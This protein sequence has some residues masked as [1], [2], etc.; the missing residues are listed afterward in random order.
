MTDQVG[1][2][3]IGAGVVGLAIGRALALAGHAPL[4]LEGEADLGSWTSSRNSE[5]IHA[6]I[7]YPQGS[8]KARLCVEGK[9]MLYAFCAQ[10]GVPHSRLGKLIF[11]HTSDQF[12]EL[13]KIQAAAKAA[14]VHD[15]VWLDRAAARALEPE[16]DCAAA[17][18]SPSTGIVDSHSLMQALLGEAEAN[19]AMLVTN[20][21][22]DRISRN[23][24]LW[25]VHIQGEAEPVVSAPILVNSGGLGAQAVAAVT[26]GLDPAFVPPLHFARGVY[27]THSG[28]VPF[29]HLIYP[30]PEPGGLGTHLTLDL[31]GQARFGPDVEWIYGLDYTVDPARH[32]KFAAAAQRIWPA[33]N[34]ERLQPGYAGI[35]PKLSGPGEAA[36]DFMIQ[37]PAVH[38]QEGLVN[39]FGIESPGLTAS[40]AI[41]AQVAGMVR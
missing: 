32:A 38:G 21:Q 37:G 20:T 36:A 40:M 4:I 11:A 6:G 10:R 16:L 26:Q 8:L 39:L 34:P 22:V 33:L 7:Y 3:V 30:V 19:G 5:V 29:S 23:G 24:G 25:Q 31:A 17:L 41:A 9:A 1:S 14:G 13:E 15:L 2:V 27:F 18:L 12:G 28:R 35:R